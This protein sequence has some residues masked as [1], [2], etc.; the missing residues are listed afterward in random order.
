MELYKDPTA[1]NPEKNNPPE[2]PENH[3]RKPM[4]TLIRFLA[5][6]AVALTA[7]S[8]ARAETVLI[9]FGNALSFRGASQNGTDSNGYSWTSI[10]AASTF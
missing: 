5:I 1:D 2:I 6:L 3:P 10:Y 4:T 7:A 9:D 8:T